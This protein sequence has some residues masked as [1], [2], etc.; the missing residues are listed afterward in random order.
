MNI[1]KEDRIIGTDLGGYPFNKIYP[2]NKDLYGT[3]FNGYKNEA[4]EVLFY[5]FVFQGYDISFKFKN[6]TYYCMYESDYVALSDCD[7][8]EK[9]QIFNDAIELIENLE[10]EGHKL[11]DI[12]NDIEEADCY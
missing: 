12:I 7:F 3:H 5:D 9:Y 4:R 8:T 1:N 2:P 10:I 6:R 11:I